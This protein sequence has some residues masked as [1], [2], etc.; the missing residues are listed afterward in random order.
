MKHHEREYFVSKVRCGY[1]LLSQTVEDKEYTFKLLTPTIEQEFIMNDLYVKTYNQLAEEGVRT[2]EEM[3][4]FLMDKGLWTF[5]EEN[6]VDKLK[7]NIN[8]CKVSMFKQRNKHQEREGARVMLRATEKTLSKLLQK[9]NV[10]QATSCEGL[11]IIEKVT[12][13]LELCTTHEGKPYDFNEI[14]LTSILDLYQSSILPDGDVR[15][16]ARTEPWKSTWALREIDSYNLFF[17]EGR[18]LSLDQKNIV[19]WSKMYDNIQESME[20]PSDSVI[21]DDDLLD[22]WFIVQKKKREKEKVDSDL[23]NTTQNDK[24]RN[25]SEVFYMASSKQEIDDI[26]DMNDIQ[27]RTM[28]KEREAVIKRKGKAQQHD[29]PDEKMKLTR[30][31]NRAFKDKFKR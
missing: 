20:C 13:Y 25:A 15:E 9:K 5:E 3:H 24:I 23:E 2:E 17:N 4:K 6:L 27:S 19:I 16:L 10:Y 29:F 11:A 1:Y 14:P 22:G 30:M 8:K 7:K 28:K 21:D 31:S 12:K 18:E 26:H